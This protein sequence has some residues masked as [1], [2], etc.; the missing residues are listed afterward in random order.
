MSPAK[1]TKEPADAFV[2]IVAPLMLLNVPIEQELQAVCADR[3][4]KVPAT[5]TTAAV[6]AGN[7]E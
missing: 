4:W 1:E 2:Q 3:L 6:T 7:A 5:Q